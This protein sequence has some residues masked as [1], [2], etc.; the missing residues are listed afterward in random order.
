M[1]RKTRM[2]EL[3]RIDEIRNFLVQGL[4]PGS[5]GLRFNTFT[6]DVLY[7][8]TG[9]DE[10]VLSYDMGELLLSQKEDAP[11]RE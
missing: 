11:G 8:H 4:E 7:F 5:Y 6:S 1:F 2:A 10:D 3:F 9:K